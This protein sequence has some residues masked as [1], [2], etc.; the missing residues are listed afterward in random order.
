MSSLALKTISV[1]KPGEQWG[2]LVLALGFYCAI[3]RA[4]SLQSFFA[5][6]KW[7]FIH[8]VSNIS[9]SKHAH[10]DGLGWGISMVFLVPLAKHFE[11][12][13]WEWFFF[14]LCIFYVFDLVCSCAEEAAG[15]QQHLCLQICTSRPWKRDTTTPKRASLILST[16]TTKSCCSEAQGQVRARFLAED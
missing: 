13:I 4:S 2:A 7:L 3:R 14:S 5:S 11:D 16:L 10:P 8:K 1:L 6:W 12:C 9:V 15:T